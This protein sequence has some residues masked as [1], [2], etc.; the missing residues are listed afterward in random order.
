MKLNKSQQAILACLQ[1]PKTRA[2]IT[3]EVGGH[4]TYLAKILKGMIELGLLEAFY[5]P[6]PP[7]RLVYRALMRLEL[8]AVPKDESVSA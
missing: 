3:A 1:T 6:A 8:V 4:P 2:E 5:L 7:A